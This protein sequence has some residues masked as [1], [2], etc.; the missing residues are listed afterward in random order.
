ME[1]LIKAVT[2][3]NALFDELY[4]KVTGVIPEQTIIPIIPQEVIDAA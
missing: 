1:G 4:T 3:D 2:E